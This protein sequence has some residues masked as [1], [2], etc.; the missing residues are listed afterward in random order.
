MSGR[1]G[2]APTNTMSEVVQT[3][4]TQGCPGLHAKEYNRVLKQWSFT[5]DPTGYGERWNQN[6]RERLGDTEAR[7]QAPQYSMGQRPACAAYMLQ[8]INSWMRKN[9]HFAIYI[10]PQQYSH[11]SKWSA[12]CQFLSGKSYRNIKT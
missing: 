10:C 3:E 8:A 6:E 1:E 9:T 4:V 7:D 11:L 12:L 5:K 2:L